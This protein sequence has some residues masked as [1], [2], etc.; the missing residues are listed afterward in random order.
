LQKIYYI[1]LKDNIMNATSRM[2]LVML[3][4]VCF[5]TIASAQVVRRTRLYIDDGSGHFTMLTGAAGGDTLTF[6]SGGG[7]ILT[8]GGLL[9][10]STETD[11]A[12][13]ANTVTISGNTTAATVVNNG[14]TALVTASVTTG[15]TGQILYLFNDLGTT[16][17][18]TLSGYTIPAGKMGIF[19]YLSNAWR[20]LPGT[21][22][23]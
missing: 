20:P 17:S 10:V 23:D 13:S 6:S 2:V 12:K 19:I 4:L 5:S 16:Q 21:S 22:I 7:S 14:S 1:I 15:T 11:T 8:T 18:I 9:I 3:A